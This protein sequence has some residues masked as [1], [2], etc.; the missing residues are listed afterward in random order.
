MV[1]GTHTTELELASSV[2]EVIGNRETSPGVSNT[3][4]LPILALSTQVR[5]LLGVA[6]ET[7]LG[8]AKG[9]SNISFAPDGTASMEAATTATLGGVIVGTGL[10]VDANGKID[11]VGD[12]VAGGAAGSTLEIQYNNTGAFGGVTGSVVDLATGSIRAP[13]RFMGYGAGG[14]TS[15]AAYGTLSLGA[16]TS[17]A[18]N[19]AFGSLALRNN[20][21]GGSNTAFGSNALT[22]NTT[23]SS[24]SAFGVSALGANT[25]GAGGTAMGAG[26]LAANT[27]GIFNTAL[28][29]S[30]LAANT[31]RSGLTA[32]GALALNALAGGGQNV[33][34][35]YQA[36]RYCVTGQNSV[37]IGY[38]ALKTCVGGDASVAI[39][40]E[41]LENYNDIEGGIAIGNQA[42][43]FCINSLANIAIGNTAQYNI[44]GGSGLN[45]SVGHHTLFEGTT[46]AGNVA[47]GYVAGRDITTGNLNTL[48]G[49]NTGRGLT[50]GSYNTI[51]GG[52]VTGLASGLS[53]AIIIADGAGAI[54]VDYNKTATAA[55]VF[56]APVIPPKST[57]AALPTGVEGM[58]AYATNG[59]KVGEGVGSG[60]GVPVYFS[61][62]SWRVYSTD[63]AVAA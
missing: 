39:G 49:H 6:T 57:V 38:N 31:I 58:V 19:C 20:T 9:G 21:S 8:F 34:V 32:V 42:L 37:A 59:R 40:N 60:T 14:V 41:A 48:I 55:W 29:A 1:D 4:R 26:A 18:N 43:K 44:T 56:A 10:V 30:A 33:A 15:N 46:C 54:K 3:V 11:V 25:S 24:N 45:V 16:N 17:G 52:Q 62:G 35:G 23:A 27:I 63:A 53:N 51:L 28:G 2:D 61:N 22:T 5:S 7:V 12:P 50:T 47:M 13:Q 36:M